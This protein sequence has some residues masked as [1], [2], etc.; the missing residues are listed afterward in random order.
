MADTPHNVVVVGTG[1]RERATDLRPGF[2]GRSGP[3]QRNL[4]SL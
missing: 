4:C 2:T 3:A 1:L